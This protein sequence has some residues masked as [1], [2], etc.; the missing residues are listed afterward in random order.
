MSGNKKTNYTLAV[1]F[2][3]L[4]ACLMLLGAATAFPGVNIINVSDTKASDINIDKSYRYTLKQGEYQVL[5]EID[6][7]T[8]TDSTFGFPVTSYYFAVLVNQPNG[9]KI[10]MEVRTREKTDQLRQGETP[11][12]FG[13][14][15]KVEGS[16][17]ELLDSA[18][19]GYKTY[20]L[21]LNDNDETVAKLYFNT[22][23]F[24]VMAGLCIFLISKISKNYQI[25]S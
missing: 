1:T 12:L 8:S 21:C 7:V 4:L 24:L 10:A 18:S 3:S 20:Y 25:A 5:E 11:E 16:E 19:N 15:S 14:I 2:L 6:E 17:A 22:A 23:I 9:E 13:M